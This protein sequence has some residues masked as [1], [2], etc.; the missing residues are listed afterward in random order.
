M[1]QKCV[2]LLAFFLCIGLVFQSA[3]VY[4][5]EDDKQTEGQEDVS[6]VAASEAIYIT[7][8]TE[9]AKKIDGENWIVSA[10]ISNYL[11]DGKFNAWTNEYVESEYAYT[12]PGGQVAICNLYAILA[13]KYP[14]AIE[15]FNK[16]THASV[17]A[18]VMDENQRVNDAFPNRAK[19]AADEGKA[20]AYIDEKGMGSFAV[21]YL[22]SQTLKSL[23]KDL[24]EPYFEFKFHLN[25]DNKTGQHKVFAPMKDVREALRNGEIVLFSFVDHEV[26]GSETVVMTGY[27]ELR[28]NEGVKVYYE[29]ADSMNKEEPHYVSNDTIKMN[30][31]GSWSSISVIQK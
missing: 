22:A 18:T 11:K 8:P 30:N 4:A 14:D 31:I 10:T 25:E 19:K 20:L 16:N 6:E 2:F 1:K 29:I 24:T 23:Q 28:T 7:D 21:H 12:N 3:T 13:T 17:M 5:T 9:D 27:Q 15:N 26:Y